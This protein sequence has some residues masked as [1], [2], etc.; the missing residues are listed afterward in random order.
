MC[1][2]RIMRDM[3]NGGKEV[4]DNQTGWCKVK[5]AG[6]GS[7]G[8]IAPEGLGFRPTVTAVAAMVGNRRAPAVGHPRYFH[9]RLLPGRFDPWGPEG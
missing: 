8:F 5:V 6:G 3:R 2:R 1:Y 4:F 7:C 9:K